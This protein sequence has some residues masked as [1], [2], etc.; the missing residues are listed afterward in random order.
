MLPLK[1]NP[2]IHL[3][4]LALFCLL[5]G[6]TA[7]AE[8]PRPVKLFLLGGQSNM[9][10][11]G[12]SEELPDA[13]R[14]PPVNVKIWDNRENLWVALGKDSTAITRN[15]L[16]GPEVAFSHRMAKVWPDDTICLVKTAAGGTKLHTQWV[17]GKGMYQRFLSNLRKAEHDLEQSKTPYEIVGMLWMQGESDSETTEMANAYE[18]NLKTLIQDVRKQTKQA[19]LPF[20]MGR[21]SSSLLKETP[22][23]FD[24]AKIVQA[25]QEAVAAQDDHVFIVNTDALSTLEDNTHFDTQAQ[26]K[27]GGEMADLMVKELKNQSVRLKGGPS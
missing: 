9:E 11:C 3:W 12:K 26:L 18:R 8:A 10:G 15:R 5:T 13:F 27:L 6:S 25:A 17:P 23:N 7:L 2:F 16:F 4:T 19:Q 24:H 1:T 20:V 22:W 14:T 21:I